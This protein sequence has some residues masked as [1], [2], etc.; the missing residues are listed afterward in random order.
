[1]GRCG[2]QMRPRPR[3]WFSLWS[4]RS[5]PHPPPPITGNGA[6]PT[7]AA[8]AR[9]TPGRRGLVAMAMGLSNSLG[10]T[11]QGAWESWDAL[12]GGSPGVGPQGWSLGPRGGSSGPVPRPQN[13]EA[14]PK[15]RS[16]WRRQ[17]C[18]TTRKWVCLHRGGRAW[19]Q[20]RGGVCRRLLPGG[21]RP[22][23]AMRDSEVF[24]R[25]SLW[26]GFRGDSYGGGSARGRNASGWGCGRT[27][28]LL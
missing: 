20:G 17:A 10:H 7:I 27:G 24:G 22:L 9:R 15:K 19:R 16:R 13:S 28:H 25:G 23:G 3:T 8:K 5:T 18:G 2:R 1:M 11:S 21:F 12:R 14:R 26:E 6:V 4:E